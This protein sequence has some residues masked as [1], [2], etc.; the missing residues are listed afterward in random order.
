MYLQDAPL[1]KSAILVRRKKVAPSLGG[2]KRVLVEFKEIP[3][4]RLAPDDL[5]DTADLCRL[6]GVS[7]RTVYRWIAEVNLRPAGKVGREHLFTKREV[8]RWNDHERPP[9]GRPW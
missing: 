1:A 9:M 5:L 7:V 4:S 6:F 3:F 8:L 2:G